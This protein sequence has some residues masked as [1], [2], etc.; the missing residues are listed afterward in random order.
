MGHVHFALKPAVAGTNATV[1]AAPGHASAA[2]LPSTITTTQTSNATVTATPGSASV[3]GPAASVQAVRNATATVAPG[4]AAA[5]GLSA[6]VSTGVSANASAAPGSATGRGLAATVSTVR[7]PTVNAAPGQAAC[8]NTQATILATTVSAHSIYVGNGYTDV[9]AQQIVRTSDD[10]LWS[11][12]F[13]PFDYYPQGTSNGLSQTLRV[14]RADQT[15]HAVV[16]YPH[17]PGT[18]PA[19]PVS[20]AMAVGADDVLHIAW[21]ERASWNSGGTDNNLKYAQFDTAA[22]T[23][24]AR[25]PSTACWLS[26]SRARAMSWS[27]A[28]DADGV[29]HIAYLKGS[30]RRCDLPQPGRRLLVGRDHGR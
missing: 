26:P 8:T 15:G 25:S 19:S 11:V 24:A 29:P 6:S 4:S 30:P 7:S 1:N 5:A 12:T 22:G 16:I 28:V 17:G 27:R 14:Y 18:Q 21:T 3:A 2:G 13:A 23:W 20:W 9:T 10:R